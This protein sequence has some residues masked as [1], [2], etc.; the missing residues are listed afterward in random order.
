M[1]D[2]AGFKLMTLIKLEET[3]TISSK[4]SWCRI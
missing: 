3:H 4:R 1:D 2:K